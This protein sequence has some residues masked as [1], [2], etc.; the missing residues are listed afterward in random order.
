MTVS[1]SEISNQGGC[2]TILDRRPVF[3]LQGRV[4]GLSSFPREPE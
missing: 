1:P 4:L 3:S 2:C